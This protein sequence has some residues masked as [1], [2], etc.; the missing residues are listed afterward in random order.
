MEW[1]QYIFLMIIIGGL[2]YM[3]HLNNRK[4]YANWNFVWHQVKRLVDACILLLIVRDWQTFLW[5]MFMFF[6]YQ[7]LVYNYFTN[8]TREG[9]LK[10]VWNGTIASFKWRSK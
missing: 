2:A 7:I 6:Y 4:P 1:Y 9:I 5:G 10:E 3:D 8:P